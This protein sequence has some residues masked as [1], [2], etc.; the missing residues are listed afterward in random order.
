MKY[1]KQEYTIKRMEIIGI[2]YKDYRCK[3]SSI[4]LFDKYVI[5]RYID[6]FIKDLIKID[7]K[8][9]VFES[10][11]ILEYSYGT[12]LEYPSRHYTEMGP[13]KHPFCSIR[14]IMLLYKTLLIVFISVFVVF[15]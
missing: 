7:D 15:F 2:F 13:I 11:T 8:T 10:K 9:Y 6:C 3:G 5:D 12:K 1:F 14:Y 4:K